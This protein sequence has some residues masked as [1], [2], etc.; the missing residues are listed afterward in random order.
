MTQPTIQNSFVAGEIS[1]SLF[2]RTDLAKYH[3][4]ASTVRNFFINYRGGASSRAGTRY[5][6][7]C[8]QQATASD[9]TPPRDIPFQFNIN[10]G[11]VLEFGD[12]YMR[13][14]SNGAYVVEAGTA[15]TGATKANPGVI[16]DVAHGYSVG[17]WVFISGVVGM[18]QLNGHTYIINTTPSA[19]TY[20]LTDLFGNVINTTAFTTYVSGGSAERIYTVVSPY[21]VEDLPYL[22]YTQSADT[23]SLTCLNQETLTDYTP[24]DL[25]RNG[26]TNWVF[27]AVTFASAIAAPA[28]VSATAH[29][30]TT[31]STY[32]SYV[33]TAVNENGEESIA[34]SVATV[35]NNDISV[36]AGSNVVTWSPV[37]DATSYNVYAATAVYNVTTPS[38]VPYG[39]AGTAY[40][41][42]FVDTN[43]IPDFTTV[44]PLHKDPFGSSNNYPGVV[45]YY[46]QRR[47]YANTIN[48]PDTYF[49]SQPGAY[50]NFDSSIPS[51]NADAI[52]GAPWAQQ[53]NGIQAMIPMTNGLIIF[54]GN[55]AWLLNG[56]N[57]SAITPSSQTAT[58]QAFNGCHSHI[59]PLLINYDVL[60]VQAKGSIVRDLSYNFFVNIF[61]G[62]DKTILSNHLFNFHQLVN[63]CYS[64]EPYKVVWAVRDDGV[65]LSL[66]YLKE[67]DIY[68]WSH[69]DTNGLFVGVC[70][71]TEPPVD[72]VYVNVK[73]YIIGQNKWMYYK[74]RM[75][76]RNWQN[77]EDCFCV[78]AGLTY[79]MTYPNA[80]LIPAAANGTNNISAVNVIAGGSNYTAP[81]V[82]AIDPTGQGSGATFSVTLTSGVITAITPLM[83]GDGYQ[84]GTRFVIADST[85]SGAAAQP[86]ITNN[87]VFTASS[88][89]F[90]SGMVGDVIRIGNNNANTTTNSAI[91]TNGGGKAIITAY[92]SATQVTANITEQITNVMPDDPYN[93]PVPVS[94][95]QWSIS[96]PTT[97]VSGLQHLEGMQVA[98]LAD[99]S[100]VS[101]QTVVDGTI[102]LPQAYSAITVGLPYTCQLQTLYLDPPGQPVTIQGKRKNI[103]AVTVRMEASRGMQ[104]GT[105]QI[106][107]STSPN[108]SIPTWVKMKEFKERNA[109]IF[110]G[111]AIPLFTGDERILV[112]GE[113]SKPGQ[114]AVQQIYPLPANVLAVI[115]EF[116]GGDTSG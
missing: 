71:V 107:Q 31:L 28:G 40:G 46:Q 114:I 83:E 26:A 41:T 45:A 111:S 69:H 27:T 96:V 97:S 1:P 94:P 93:R 50:L 82:S 74:E 6:G 77:V 88:G 32:Y 67:Q 95:N 57:S 109:T 81:T 79:P 2:A 108:N 34:S 59:A 87:V 55:G 112:D 115:P 35:Q 61:T 44:P 116:T 7:A 11:Y 38:G 86:I 68:A 84:P 3:N 18:T 54:T 51:T 90:N 105:N 78:D 21:A 13:I 39:Y 19:D 113:W 29:A 14:V 73:R 4:G 91:T 53:I 5:V 110:A 98:I 24:Y 52:T 16:T 8:K 80:T 100:V 89:V 102:T 17:D 36:N 9:I 33:V 10:Q 92:T 62:E 106:D 42:S 85:G 47:A 37:T 60:Y 58:A 99:G 75:D 65:M 101:N 104:V 30:S 43:I 15:I 23:M 72:A 56:G 12:E 25:K 103:Q 70:S 49:L 20:T 48:K 64:E 66:T 76:N 22:K 63:W